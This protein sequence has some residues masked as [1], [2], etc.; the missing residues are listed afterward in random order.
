MCTF[1]PDI[2]TQTMAPRLSKGDRLAYVAR[3]REFIEDLLEDAKDS[4]WVYQA[5]I[6]C[7]LI[8][9]K[10]EGSLS[11]EAKEEVQ[12]WLV[13]LRK[14]DPLRKGRWDDLEKSLS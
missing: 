10:V 5:L 6:E 13:E 9:A 14:L 8:A 12:I 1:D 2:A 7:A 11:V 4:K 3:E